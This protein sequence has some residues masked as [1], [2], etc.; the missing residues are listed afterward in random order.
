VFECCIANDAET[1]A[2][3]DQHMVKADIGDGGCRDERQHTSARHVL[4]AVRWP[5]GDSGA[6]PPLV[7]RCPRHPWLHREDLP[8]KGLDIP[9]GDELRTAAVHDVQLLAALVSARLR[10]GL[11]EE[12]L[13]VFV[14]GLIVGLVEE[15]LEVFV[16]GFIPQLPL[17][18]S[19]IGIGDLLLAG[20]PRR[21]GTFS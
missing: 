15:T 1:S 16:G 17:S 4:R 3:V 19:C 12:T 6:L 10:V 14:G 2:F 20:P 18:C 11:V 21:G 9:S 13:E 7:G 8:A 5:K